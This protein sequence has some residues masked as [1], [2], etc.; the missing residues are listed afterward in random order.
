MSNL[1][2]M[3]T[4]IANELARSDLTTEIGQ[5]I[6]SAIEHHER[7]RFYF[8]ETI[9]SVT[10]SI[11]Q[12]WYASADAAW[13]ASAVDIDS[14]RVTINSRP[15]PVNKRTMAELEIVSG[16]STISGDPTDWCYY[17]QQIRLYPVPSA[18]RVL[19]G[20][21]IQRFATM[22][23]DGDS[24]AWMNDAEALIRTRAKIMLWEEV[25]RGDAG[26]KEGEFLRAREADYLSRL[27]SETGR[28]GRAGSVVAEYL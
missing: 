22:T 21:Y 12:E 6:Q 9:A 18:A 13:I 10:A 23:A 26:K 4:R 17:Q 1:G 3:K 25:I 27:L 5:A 7:R 14:L 28:R 16:G 24:N 11:G 2:T 20:A 19:T 8:N 15:Y